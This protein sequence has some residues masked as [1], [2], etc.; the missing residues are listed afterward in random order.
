MFVALHQH[1]RVAVYGLVLAL[2]SAGLVSRADEPTKKKDKAGADTPAAAAGKTDT[3]RSSSDAKG[4]KGETAKVERGPFRCEISLKGVF[5]SSDMAEVSVRLEAATPLIVA[6]VAEPGTKVKKGDTILTFDAEKVDRAIRDLEAD[7]ALAELTL[8]Q[9]EEELPLLERGTPLE[10]ASAAKAKKEAD[11]DLKNYLDI[12]KNWEQKSAK[13]AV[14]NYADY[15]EYAKE[16]LKQLQ[17]MYRNKDL[18][19]ETEEIILKRQRNRVEMISFWLDEMAVQRDHTLAFEIPRREQTFRDAAAKAALALDKAKTT[20]PLTLSQRRL[21]LAKAKYERAR[22]TEHLDRVRHDRDV[23]TVKSPADGVVYYGRCIRGQWVTASDTEKKLVRG[24]SIQPD[25]V[26]ITVVEPAMLFVRAAVDEK[27]LSRVTPGA[28]AKVTPTA[29]PDARLPAKVKEVLSA[30]RAAG[31]F[32][33]KVE[34]E[35]S[36][37]AGVTAGMTCAVKLVD[38]RKAGALTVPVAAVTREDDEAYVY[39]DGQDKPQKRAV[40]TGHT[41]GERVEILEGLHEGDVIRLTK[42]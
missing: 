35:G 28:V 4:S 31:V 20:L 33:A 32:D 39:V 40:K 25:E 30:P 18:T 42:P 26:F 27:E 14:K 41:S 13:F 1:R 38:Y 8:K 16:E 9:A 17:K 22:A 21:A 23:L 34:L 2:A 6:T 12:E 19:E 10:L 3:A 5:E 29:L 37:P 15:L 11:E 36:R 7:K 24:G